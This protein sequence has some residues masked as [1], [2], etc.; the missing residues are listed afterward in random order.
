MI[1]GLIKKDLY[2]LTAY[3]TSMIIMVLFC[4]TII[5]FVFDCM[6]LLYN[7]FLIYVTL[8]LKKVQKFLICR[9]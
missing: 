3:K 1:K 6:A 5:I 4:H 8:Q 7:I 9:Y 2:N